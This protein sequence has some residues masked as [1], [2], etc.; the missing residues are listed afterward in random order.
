MRIFLAVLGLFRVL[1]TIASH[2][3]MCYTGTKVVD[4]LNGIQGFTLEM[5]ARD[6]KFPSTK[7]LRTCAM[8]V[9]AIASAMIATL[10]LMTVDGKHGSTIFLGF[11]TFA[12]VTVQN[13]IHHGQ[14]FFGLE[15]GT[16][17]F[18]TT[19]DLGPWVNGIVSIVIL[20]GA[21]WACMLFV[22]GY[23]TSLL[24]ALTFWLLLDRFVQLMENESSSTSLLQVI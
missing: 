19:H 7:R 20:V 8:V 11:S 4:I 16:G 3:E 9:L 6:G 22:I 23:M 14:L 18:T 17:N 1:T 10:P 15:T 2:I 12:Q 5:K 13:H 24:W 21:W